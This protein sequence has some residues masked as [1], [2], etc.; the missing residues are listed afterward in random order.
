[1][2]TGAAQT[3]RKVL[4]RAAA[5]G[6]PAILKTAGWGYDG[7]GQCRINAPDETAAAWDGLGGQQGVL[8]ATTFIDRLTTPGSLIVD[9]FVGSGTIVPTPAQV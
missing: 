6:Y 4:A 5:L 8:E 3:G 7:K 1:M 2:L 9:P